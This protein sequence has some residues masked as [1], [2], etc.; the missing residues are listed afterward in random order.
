M[1]YIDK[2]AIHKDLEPENNFRDTETT[3]P[4]NLTLDANSPLN[5]KDTSA[6]APSDGGW[7]AWLSRAFK[8]V[9]LLVIS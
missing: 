5:N 7:E 1:S 8:F 2:P 3:C 9:P 4:G 6:G